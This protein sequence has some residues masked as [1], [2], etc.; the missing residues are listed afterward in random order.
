MLVKQKVI[1][2]L[3]LIV[4]LSIAYAC[5]SKKEN[6]TNESVG[7]LEMIYTIADEL[8]MQ[9]I[10]DI[11]LRGGDLYQKASVEELTQK[12]SLY[13][14]Q[15]YEKYKHHPSFWGWYL[16]NE[17]NPIENS[18]TEQSAFWR[19]IWKSVV[20]KCHQVA[21]GSKVTISP[22]FL[23]DKES[24]RGFKYQEPQEYE[25]WWYSTMNETGIDIL[26][27]QDSGAE[28][29]SFY[30]LA[31][32]EPFFA[33]FANACRRA[34]KEFW[35]NVETGQVEAQDWQHALQMEKDFSRDW[36]FTEIDWLKQKL[37]LAARY[38]TGIINWGYY[39]LMTPTATQSKLIIQDIDGQDVDLSQRKANYEAYK[40]YVKNMPTTIGEGS[41]T[42]PKL[43]GT[44]WFLPKIS[45]EYTHQELEKA[46][47]EEIQNQKDIGFN[48][49]WICNTPDHFVAD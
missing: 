20:D 4:S 12:S 48:I 8:D 26:M 1:Y 32:R 13:I 46:V 22:F 9:V 15:Y 7:V 34:G 40:T 2:I 29:L 35:V 47:R 10:C 25:E 42:L 49:L 21:P 5:S 16:N 30:T 28:H 27:L 3:V 33:A 11:D 38:G 39:P 6:K 43:N 37:D 36:A 14:E 44:L 45:E 18:D 23:L 41:L 31:D 24:L 17:I 19:T